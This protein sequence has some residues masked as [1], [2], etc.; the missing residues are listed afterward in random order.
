MLRIT[1]DLSFSVDIVLQEL[2]ERSARLRARSSRLCGDSAW[3][4]ARS[5]QLNRHSTELQTD[6]AQVRLRVQ[7]IVERDNDRH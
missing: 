7:S 4:H 1:V 2:L 3:L 5:S 6:S